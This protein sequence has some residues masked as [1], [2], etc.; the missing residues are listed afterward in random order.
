MNI[1]FASHDL[2]PDPGSGGTGRYVAEIGRELADRGHAISV[3]TRRRGDCP[4][5]ETLQGIDVYRFDIRIAGQS[6]LEIVP[7]LP[8]V[9]RTLS[10]HL[11]RLEPDLVSFQGPVTSLF[12]HRLLDRTIPR[13]CTFHSPWPAEYR[14]RTRESGMTNVRRYL[15]V[16][17]RKYLERTVVSSADE[18]ITLS[19]FMR[20][21]L[22]VQYPTHAEVA[23]IPGGV[24]P[25]KFSPDAGVHTR[26]SSA[27]PSFLTVRRLSPRMGHDLL[28]N[29]FKRVKERHPSAELFVAGDGPLR[30]RLAVRAD[31]LGIGDHTNFLGFVPDD[32]LPA[33]YASADVFVLPTT[34]LEG[35]GLST[36]EALASGTPVVGTPVGGTVDLLGDVESQVDIPERMLLVGVSIDELAERM[37][38]WADV[39]PQR[40]LE[41]GEACSRYV[42]QRYSW[43][44]TV[45]ALEQRYK[46]LHPHPIH[47]DPPG[48]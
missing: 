15:N 48:L 20:G 17:L 1:V 10:S 7:Q 32:E 11:D 40:C 3:I 6:G 39:S 30:D 25:D 38:A 13:S 33:L 34:E 43:A 16:G 36:L 14:L 9:Y 27:S 45:D 5:H 19:K 8:R 12:V 35:F 21:K 46:D 37:L 41:A 26:L 29:A 4:R 31:S 2:H 28:F 44:K 18:V 24:N 23:V 42:S 22:R 47:A